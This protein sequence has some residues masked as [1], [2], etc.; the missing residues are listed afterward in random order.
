[1]AQ[2]LSN[3]PIGAKIKFGKHSIT[4]E[5]AE[6]IIWTIVA[7]NHTDA[8]YPSKSVT[9]LTDR[10]I[11][12]R[13]F[14]APEP[15]NNNS[16]IGSS[17]NNR[18]SLSNINTWLNSSAGEG[19]WYIATHD[20][21]E[22]PSDSS[23]YGSE[24]AYEGNPGF[25]YYFTATERNAILNA[26]IK[27][28][29]TT[30]DGMSLTYDTVSCKIFLPSVTEVGIENEAA[31]SEGDIWD[32]FGSREQR[33]R[34]SYA[35]QQVSEYCAFKD[36][37]ALDQTWT[38]RLR[39]PLISSAQHVRNV[40]TDGGVNTATAAAGYIG[41][42]PAT[43][44]SS[45]QLVSDTTDLDGCY[46]CVWNSAPNT[47][48]TINVSPNPLIAGEGVTVSWSTVTDPDGDAVQYA[49][50][51]SI[52]GGAFSSL[53]T[54]TETSY[55]LI[56]PSSGTKA[57]YRVRAYDK[58]LAYSSYRTSENISILSNNA[59]EI[60][61]ENTDLGAKSEGFT[62]EYIVSD[63][64]TEQIHITERLN[65]VT[66]RTYYAT[67]GAT[68]TLTISGSAWLSLPNGV[69]TITITAKDNNGYNVVERRLTFTKLVNECTVKNSIPYPAT[70]MPTRI[71]VEVV[72][73]APPEALFKVEVC[74]NGYD[75]SPTWEDATSTV[76]GGLVHTFSNNKKTATNWG[77]VIRVTLNR[78]GGSGDCY[79]KSIG[80]NFE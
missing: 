23:T 67:S 53:Y 2:Y 38:W 26:S 29:R 60:S 24:T 66:Q 40:S 17:G 63:D 75:S 11:D 15:S 42:R 16:S 9:L 62:Y 71:K 4:G 21:D 45:S 41:V 33:V 48:S 25:L 19:Q 80:G 8:G 57:Q 78:N 20:A 56:A 13:C 1:M 50:E 55:K 49:L 59:P 76:K 14:D 47:P 37:P 77:V 36:K 43:N 7:K 27:T 44:I 70:T 64:H 28:L 65:G 54:G 46:T 22:P 74:N 6:D 31:M 69:H 61:G 68:N 32:L 35:T 10:I 51:Q 58:S 79:I 73:N 39:T 12:L 52:N 72:R 3:L 18:Y 5:P 34:I 30:E